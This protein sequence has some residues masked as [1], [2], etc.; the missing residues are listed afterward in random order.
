MDGSSFLRRPEASNVQ[1]LAAYLRDKKNKGSE[2]AAKA[3]ELQ[4][5]I[6]T[7]LAERIRQHRAFGHSAARNAKKDQR[8][9]DAKIQLQQDEQ[10][11]AIAKD[12]KLAQANVLARELE[13]KR[14]RVEH[15]AAQA[16]V[17]AAC[18]KCEASAQVL[19][20]L[21]QVHQARL[22]CAL[23]FHSKE[24]MEQSG[25]TG[26]AK[27]QAKSGGGEGR[28]SRDASGV[29]VGKK[30]S[31]AMKGEERQTERGVSTARKS[32]DASGVNGGRRRLIKSVVKSGVGITHSTHSAQA[33]EPAEEPRTRNLVLTCGGTIIVLLA[34]AV[35]FLFHTANGKS[36]MEDGRSIPYGRFD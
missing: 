28:K 21:N 20:F 22:D 13:L 6:H 7:A 36:V 19:G 10:E 11:A 18:E 5:Y 35:I 17:R 30:K 34:V 16:G 15:K 23:L 12:R 9:R 1:S 24:S 27:S 4:S 25:E 33:E 2:N 29:N 8:E 3:A 14:A 26:G 32:R 31:R